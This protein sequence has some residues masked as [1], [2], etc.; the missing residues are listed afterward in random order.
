V[1]LPGI[2]L[3]AL[4]Q[5]RGHGGACA[6]GEAR[7]WIFCAADARFCAQC[8]H[9]LETRCPACSNLTRAEAHFCRRCGQG[10]SLPLELA[11]PA[12]ALPTSPPRTPVLEERLD[13]LQRYL[14]QYLTEKILASRGCL[15]GERKLVTVLFAD[16]AD[17]TVLGECLGEEVL[18]ALMDEVYELFIHEVHRYEG[19]VNELT[20][21]GIVAFFG[22]LLAVERAPQRA[23]HAALALQRAVARL[24]SRLEQERGVRLQVRV[25][26]NSGPVIVG[27]VGNNLRMGY[28]A[29]ADTVNLATCLEQTAAPGSIRITAQT[30]RQVASDFRCDDLGLVRLQGKATQVQ[31]YRVAGERDVHFALRRSTRARHHPSGGAG[32]RAGHERPPGRL[33]LAGPYTA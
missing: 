32:A 4:V 16:I 13:Q 14:P 33:A 17:Y 23:V 21:H 12:A 30:Y 28:K 19:T 5:R 9:P 10:L 6:A 22:A 15:E 25:G 3:E 18:F 27:T 11:G 7:W 24:S 31:A 2:D 29:V 8:G 20:E 26:I 1:Q